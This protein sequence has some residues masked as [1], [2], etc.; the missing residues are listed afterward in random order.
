[1]NEYRGNSHVSVGINTKNPAIARKGRPYRPHPK[2]S[3]RLPVM[4]RK[5]YVRGDTV[6]CTLC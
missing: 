2:A 6:P 4:G 1:M 3:V 5:R